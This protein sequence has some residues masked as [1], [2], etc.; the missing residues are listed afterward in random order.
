[1]NVLFL[2][3]FSETGGGQRCLLDLLP[4]IAA[5]GGKL[6]AAIPGQGRM[7]GQLQAAGVDVSEIPCGPYRSGAKMP[8]D[9]L[10]FAADLVRQTRVLR[11]IAD[12]HRVDLIYANGPRLWPA[13]ASL[14]RGRIPTI[15][16]AHINLGRELQ[17]RMAGWAIRRCQATVIACCESAAGPLRGFAR[18]R[19]R[20][21]PNGTADCGY[22]SHDFGKRGWRIGLIGRIAPEK[23]QLEFVEAAARLRLPAGSR[24]VICGAPMFT[25]SRYFD[26]LRRAAS[27]LPIEFTGW[28][29]DIDQVLAGLDV[30]VIASKQEAMPRVMLEAFSAGVPV[31]AFDVGGVG[32]VIRDEV[33]GFLTRQTSAVELGIRLR[34][35]ITDPE[36]L[37]RVAANARSSW[38]RSYTLDHYR[39]GIMQE[40]DRATGATE[41]LHHDRLLAKS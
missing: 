33:T 32:E 15:F 23:G 11:P 21:V 41:S 31:V 28:R 8:F 16:H 40:I 2:D 30:L 17:A 29:D 18:G 19:L 38:Q 9:A 6:L 13:A 27:G 14:S 1:M 10:R 25:D 24:F 3:Q 26:Q 22:R 39:R 7:V 4:A 5:R 35:V 20:V 36:K 37:R 34:Q 12:A